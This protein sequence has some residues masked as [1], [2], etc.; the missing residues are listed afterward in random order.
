MTDLVKQALALVQAGDWE[1]AH[2]LVAAEES[3]EAAW[4]H[5]HI[6]RI[7]G[8]LSNARYWYRRAGKTEA[9]GPLEEELAELVAALR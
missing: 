6:H 1:A 4:L 8:D 3:V 9:T 5:A 7:E 2:Q